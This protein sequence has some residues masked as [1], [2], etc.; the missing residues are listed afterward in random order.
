MVL[1]CSHEPEESKNEKA[2]KCP[3]DVTSSKEGTQ[4]SNKHMKRYGTLSVITEMQIKV[5]M[6]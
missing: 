4:R 2:P 1:E 6:R 5:S 3:G